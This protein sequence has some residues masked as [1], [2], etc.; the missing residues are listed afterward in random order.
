[1][2]NVTYRNKNSVSFVF[3]SQDERVQSTHEMPSFAMKC[4]SKGK[5]AKGYLAIKTPVAKTSPWIV[6]QTT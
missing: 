6:S 1:M 2:G 4:K 3:L 5:K